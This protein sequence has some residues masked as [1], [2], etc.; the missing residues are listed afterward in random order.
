MLPRAAHQE[1]HRL[2]G[3]QPDDVRP[4]AEKLQ[5]VVVVRSFQE[6]AEA[7]DAAHQHLLATRL[8]QV[9]ADCWF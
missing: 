3:D 4:V 5:G 2:P 6:A 1:L 9:L 8:G 7:L